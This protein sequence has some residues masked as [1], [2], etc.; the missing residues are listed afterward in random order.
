MPYTLN[1]LTITPTPHLS[2]WAARLRALSALFLLTFLA[3]TPLCAQ[4]DPED[5]TSLGAIT[6]PAGHYRI[7]EDIDA[8]SFTASLATFSGTLE[9]AIDPTTHMPYRI[10]GLTVPLFTELTGTVRNLVL[11]DVVISR[12]GQVGAVACTASG[13]A[14]I[15]NVGILGGSVGS[16]GTSTASDATD[17]CGGLVGLLDGNSSTSNAPR[18]VNCYSYADITGG[19]RVGGIVGYNNYGTNANN[20]RSMVFGCMF[21]GNINVA[22]TSNRAPIYNGTEIPN[23]DATGVSNYNYFRAEADYV[24]Q[25]HIDKY[26]CAL[27]A[28]TRFLQRF[29]FF[30][31]ILN[32][33]RELAAWW[34]TG[35]VGDTALIMKWVMLPDNI[36]SE[37][38]YPVLMKWGRY[39]SVVNIDAEHAAE[40]QPRNKGG[41][42]GELTV[43]VHMGTRGTAPYG[44]PTGAALL[45]EADSTTGFTL[46]IT[47]KDPD[48]FNFNY[49]KVQLP[50]YNDVGT[51]NYTGNRVVTG[52]KIV[53]I[54]GGTKGTFSTDDDATA[55]ASTGAITATPYNFADRNTWAKD[56]YGEGGSY[57]IFNQGAYWD[58]PNGVTEITIEPYWAEAAYAA[59]DYRDIVYNGAMST[60]NYNANIGGGQWFN[61]NTS[62]TIN[63]SSQKAY[64]A[65]SNARDNLHLS[66]A[67]SVYD[68]AI[69]LIGNVHQNGITS[70]NTSH[71]YTIM[72]VDLDNDHEPDY[73]LFQRFDGR[74]QV[75]PVRIDFLNVPGLGMAQKSTGSTGSYNFGIMQPL[76][77]FEVTNTALFRVTQFEYDRKNRGAAPYILQGGVMEQWVSG[78]NDEVNNQTTYYLVG[79]NVWFKEFH[80]GCH[81]DKTFISKHPPVSVTGGDYDEFY[82]TGLYRGD[83]SSYA[84]NAECYINGGRF[85]TLAGAAMEGI[86]NSGGADNTGNIV[87]QIQHAD[88]GEFYGGGLN[89]LHPVEG[90]ITTVVTGSHI[91]LFCGGPKFGDM[92]SGKTVVTT[93]TDCTFGTYFGA[94][95]GGNSYSRYAPSNKSDINGD[96][97]ESN[98]NNFVNDNYKQEYNS[99]YGGVS[100]TYTYQYL[101]HSNNTQNVARILVDFV[102][103][104]LAI[105]H[106]VTS[107][108]T[109]CI[110]TDNFYGGGSLGKV[111]GN[112]T[113]TL[114]GCTIGGNA[115]GA[116]FSATLPEVEV[117]NLGGFVTAPY[118][119]GNLGSYLPAVFPSTVT[120]TWEHSSTVN[121]TSTAI[122]K[123]SHILY[124]TKDLTTLGTVTGNVSLTIDGNSVVGTEGDATTGSVYGGG[125]ESTVTGDA[126]VLLKGNTEVLGDVY[127]GGKRGSVGGSTTVNIGE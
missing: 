123:T 53:S 117:M 94:G 62:V 26:N 25:R 115:F 24:Q 66:A 7:T 88:I 74:S 13:S 100:V 126:A 39:P 124:T 37:H 3:A 68:H 109:D 85:G 105:T 75:H 15:Y 121:N 22:A 9:A 127:G 70:N 48:H 101:P 10:S 55:D 69:V 35:N 4:S 107:T 79:G 12:S 29:E 5:I 11:D 6:D 42:L 1:L 98:W 18:V 50:Y 81:Q 46:N 67:H 59:D 58:V 113:S 28:E 2:T 83:I 102:S 38:P 92:N 118:Y 78:Q 23:K 77:W 80:R 34:V 19:N 86:G 72:S 96:Y 31:H 49:Y 32:G 56:Y 106:S 43:K 87:W 71:P 104:S 16:T 103:F 95:Y 30:R 114:T 27:M 108:L 64:S 36:G 89:A 61:N 47:D 33:H 63:G 65:L 40:G 82:L 54:S 41:K 14:R 120:Y 45:R 122:N 99:S 52:W 84:D 73:T 93:A 76:G 57:R 20:L 21:Y 110:V 8:A 60:K 44:A 17:C 97:G 112:V 90:N 119:D 91:D 111:E 125:E 51:G 116:G